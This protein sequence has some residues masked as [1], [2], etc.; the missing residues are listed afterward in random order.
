MCLS[1]QSRFSLCSYGAFHGNA[2]VV[3]TSLF[4]RFM[5]MC[6]MLST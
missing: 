5:Y 1:T 6:A 3:E 4:R 2:Y